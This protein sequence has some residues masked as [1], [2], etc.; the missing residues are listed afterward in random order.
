[1]QEVMDHFNRQASN[2]PDNRYDP[3]RLAT[4]ESLKPAKCYVGE[5]MWEGYVL[6]E[7]D[8]STSVLEKPF[9]GN[10]TYVLSGD[11]KALVRKSKRNLRDLP[12]EA[13]AVNHVG[14]WLSRI[15]RVR[16]GAVSWAKLR[17]K[18]WRQPKSTACGK[19]RRP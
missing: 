8:D 18:Q 3:A 10:A 2:C 13:T 16:R 5:T 1:M 4:I 6:F 15:V 17:G 7:F 11:W 9:H 12:E 19:P 14:D